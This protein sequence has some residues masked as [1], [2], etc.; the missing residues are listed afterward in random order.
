MDFFIV[1]RLSQNLSCLINITCINSP[2]N[3]RVDTIIKNKQ[4][5]NK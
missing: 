4:R 2:I 1:E 3:W 5:N